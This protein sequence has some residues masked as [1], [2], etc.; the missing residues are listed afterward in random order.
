VSERDEAARTGPPGRRRQA[1]RAEAT[2]RVL[3]GAARALFAEHGYD[4]TPIE[5]ILG[6]TGLSKGAFYHHFPDKRELLA[7]VYEE[8]ETELVAMLA[9]VG[10][11][12][13]DPLDAIDRG[14][15][16]FLDACLDPVVRRIAL[17]DAP[18]AL[19]WRRWREI[20]AR[21]GFGLLLA[22]LRSAARSGR[23]PADRLE[24]RG[25]LLLASLMEAAMLVGESADPEATRDAV[26]RIV[27]EQIRALAAAASP[28]R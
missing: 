4:A 20:D 7:A 5:E 9:A 13:T 18:A 19:G 6:R 25:H 22:G 12:A 23:I 16:G 28:P 26:G 17:V 1:D 11:E 27:S 3:V 8:M 14:C 21:H 15:Q 2:R 10:R 24:V